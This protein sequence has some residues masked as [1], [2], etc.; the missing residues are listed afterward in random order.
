VAAERLS[1]DALVCDLDGVIYRG[2]QVVP[3]AREALAA[4]AEAG[5][6][7]VFCT[8]HSR[9]TVSQYQERLHGFGID[10]AQDAIVTSAVATGATLA[11]RG[12]AG[13][14]ARV[15]GQDGVHEALAAAGIT[16]EDD[17]MR[18]DVDLVVVGWDDRFDYA[19]MKQA[20][21][22]VRLGAAFIATN[23][24]A[25]LPRAGEVWPGAG[26]I[27]AAVAVASGRGPEVIGKP[28]RAMM[29]AV[30]QR[31]A[32]ASRIAI[33]GDSP[34]SDLAGGHLM[35][36]ATVLVLTGVT[37]RGAAAAL[38]PAPDLTL[39]SIADLP[40]CVVPAG[41]TRVDGRT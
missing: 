24:D 1:I 23:D 12:L 39:D 27:C 35:G 15:I 22:A 38:V 3:G 7:V 18:V 19:A 32:G 11:R 9:L 8:N 28:H 41:D 14:R 5:I 13:A 37:D 16:V 34:E 30:A 21:T 31:L 4:L 2:E 10:V 40:D 26:A 20:A 29:D 33:V 36:W 25:T 6:R 17:P